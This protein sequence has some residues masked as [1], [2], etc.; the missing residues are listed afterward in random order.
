MEGKLAE[1]TV[2]S[3]DI[4]PQLDQARPTLLTTKDIPGGRVRRL[5]ICPFGE[6]IPRLLASDRITQK[7]KLWTELGSGY[8]ASPDQ[9][10]TLHISTSSNWK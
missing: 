7:R 8:L 10:A 5:L 1:V 4:A 3:T 6:R 2:G 9:L